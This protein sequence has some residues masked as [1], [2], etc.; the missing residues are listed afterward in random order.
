MIMNRA[1]GP[2]P[3][4]CLRRALTNH[5]HHQLHP[6][7]KINVKIKNIIIGSIAALAVSAGTLGA[8]SAQATGGGHGGGDKVTLC[9]NGHTITVDKHAA[10]AHKKH[11][12]KEGKC[13]EP[14]PDPTTEQPDPDPTTE[15]PDPDPT[16]ES[17]DPDPTTE[18]PNPD[19]TTEAP[20]PDPTTEAPQPNPTT[21][22]PV[23]GDKPKGNNPKDAAPIERQPNVDRN[24][25]GQ[26]DITIN[27][28]GSPVGETGF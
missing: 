1:R 15:A 21:A 7:R 16:T 23:K 3:G 27:N 11:G 9:H 18:A 10:K 22:P 26:R 20:D 2:P 4:L 17:P 14:D 24:N 12:D 25:D 13:D 28:D 19:P 6:T 5:H 8:V